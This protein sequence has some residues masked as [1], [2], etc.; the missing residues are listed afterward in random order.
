MT[1]DTDDN[2]FYCMGCNKP[3]HSPLYSI[4]RSNEQMHFYPGERLPE[5]EVLFAESIGDYCS[6]ACLDLN[7]DHLLKSHQVRSTY[8]G[9]GPVESCSRCGNPVD[10]S[11]PHW[12]WTEEM[13]DVVWGQGIEQIQPTEAHLLAVLC[14]KCDLNSDQSLESNKRIEERVLDT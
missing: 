7:R 6:Q 2:A 13:A 12:T 14:R 5:A 11:R 1:D 10:M 8:P 4:T 3:F 9:P